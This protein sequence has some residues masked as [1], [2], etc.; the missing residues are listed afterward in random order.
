[1]FWFAVGTF[2]VASLIPTTVLPPQSFA[3]WDKAQH[4]LAF[5]L[6][7]GLGLWVYSGF[8]SRVVIG[9]ILYGALIEF[10]QAIAGWRNGDLNDW[11]ADIVGIAAA[12]VGW[13]FLR[14][15]ASRA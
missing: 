4:A 10:A 14:R 11:V 13:I 5:L 6:F 2:G 15:V 8:S 12:Y 9:L 7:G 1:M 3:V